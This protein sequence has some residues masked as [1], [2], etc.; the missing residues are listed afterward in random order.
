[1][2]SQVISPRN[3]F[4]LFSGD[5]H[6]M[7]DIQIAG[8]QRRWGSSVVRRQTTS[9]SPLCQ[10]SFWQ[11]SV[12]LY[13]WMLKTKGWRMPCVLRNG[14]SEIMD[15]TS[16]LIVPGT[17]E[18]DFNVFS[19][20]PKKRDNFLESFRAKIPVLL[21]KLRPILGKAR[22]SCEAL[23]FLASQRSL[24]QLN[25]CNSSFPVHLAGSYVHLNLK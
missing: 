24:R 1:M 10:H 3:Q 19:W 11:V 20:V 4:P 5:W 16:K 14:R 23:L 15:F 18:F 12:I 22:K 13:F 17:G 25:F 6:R 8:G 21:S 7:L 9:C 2:L